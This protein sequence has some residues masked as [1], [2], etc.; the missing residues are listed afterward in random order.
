M[1]FRKYDIMITCKALDGTPEFNPLTH[2]K[3]IVLND[4][5]LSPWQYALAYGTANGSVHSTEPLKNP[6][7]YK[8][9]P[10]NFVSLLCQFNSCSILILVQFWFNADFVEN[11]SR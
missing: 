1:I 11:L 7:Y 10:D 8:K 5:S 6:S 4:M 9:K 3:S 2:W